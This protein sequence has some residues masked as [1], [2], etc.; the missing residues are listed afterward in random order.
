MSGGILKHA[1]E[2]GDCVG[3]YVCHLDG[4]TTDPPT[5]PGWY[6]VKHVAHNEIT[7][8]QVCELTDDYLTTENGPLYVFSHF[9]GPLPQPE[10]P[11]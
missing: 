3:D 2:Q 8:T 6:W 10:P 1:Y 7:M 5:E 9:L 4:W 11:K